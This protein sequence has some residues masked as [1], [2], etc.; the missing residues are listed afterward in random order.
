ML[1]HMAKLNKNINIP[2]QTDTLRRRPII[3]MCCGYKEI[4]EEIWRS[5]MKTS[6]NNIQFIDEM[7][8]RRYKCVRLHNYYGPT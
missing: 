3:Y 7:T 8:Q 4:R 1:N 6:L 2:K 5:R